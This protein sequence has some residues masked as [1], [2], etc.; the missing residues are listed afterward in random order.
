MEA[1]L[2]IRGLVYRFP[3]SERTHHLGNLAN[4]AAAPGREPGPRVSAGFG[5]HTRRLAT[6]QHQPTQLNSASCVVA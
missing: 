3:N 5:T 2:Q 6:G 4:N 1:D